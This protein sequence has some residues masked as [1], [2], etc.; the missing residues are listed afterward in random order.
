LYHR[1]L[2]FYILTVSTYTILP[3]IAGGLDLSFM[4]KTT[5]GTQQKEDPKEMD[6]YFQIREEDV[7]PDIE[8]KGCRTRS[9]MLLPKEK[10]NHY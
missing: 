7:L 8:K 1:R 6:R 5:K 3:S 9:L 4:A 10:R 2:S